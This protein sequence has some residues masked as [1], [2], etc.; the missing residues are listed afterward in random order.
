M[1]RR[2]KP[3][4]TCGVIVERISTTTTRKGLK[5]KTDLNQG[6]YSPDAK[7][8]DT[9]L[10]VVASTRTT[11]TANGT[12]QLYPSRPTSSCTDSPSAPSPHRTE[13]RQSAVRK[14][15][16]YACCPTDSGT[17]SGKTNRPRADAALRLASCH[18]SAGPD[19]HEPR[20]ARDH[21][22]GARDSR[23]RCPITPLRNPKQ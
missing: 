13:R 18:G 10:A 5:V 19:G 7:V 1:N 20:T 23:H 6:Y 21:P 12:T 8:T 11:G 4:T 2:G 17:E 16:I 3:L 9:E 15:H 14:S 22:L